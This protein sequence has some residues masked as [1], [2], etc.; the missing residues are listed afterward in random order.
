MIGISSVILLSGYLVVNSVSSLLQPPS[1]PPWE[2]FV[3]YYS[4]FVP[5]NTIINVIMFF[6]YWNRSGTLIALSL[7][8]KKL[9]AGML[10]MDGVALGTGLL[11]PFPF[12]LPVI[13]IIS[14]F[15]LSRY[16]KWP[17][18]SLALLLLVIMGIDLFIHALLPIPYSIVI[19][20][21]IGIFVI[22]WWLNSRKYFKDNGS[23]IRNNGSNDKKDNK[24][25]L[26]DTSLSSAVNNKSR[27]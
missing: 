22:I 12:Q 13:F 10:I 2:I 25:E 23:N 14:L 4:I 7:S 5:I 6:Q 17:K 19:D 9:I 1:S 20:E 26:E 18:R 11:V 3:I 15:M 16:W 24:K 21:P 8:T 27:I